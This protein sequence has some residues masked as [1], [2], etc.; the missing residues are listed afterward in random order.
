MAGVEEV[1]GV[2]V[3]HGEGVETGGVPDHVGGEGEFLYQLWDM[4]ELVRGSR[5]GRRRRRTRRSGSGSS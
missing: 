5:S 3:G 4:R 2:V 1:A